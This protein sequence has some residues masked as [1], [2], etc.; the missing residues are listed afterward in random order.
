MLVARVHARKTRTLS[1]VTAIARANAA[2]RSV[3]ANFDQNLEALLRMSLRDPRVCDP[4][5]GSNHRVG[6][7]STARAVLLL[8]SLD[9]C[10]DVATPRSPSKSA[11][12]SVLSALTAGS[13]ALRLFLIVSQSSHLF[14]PVRTKVFISPTKLCRSVRR[15][16]H[17]EISISVFMKLASD[18]PGRREALASQAG[19]LSRA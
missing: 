12:V 9:S 13:S 8:G 16:S 5:S 2:T 19:R 7:H 3:R 10:H 14:A 15:S 1:S 17:P 11:A 18:T 4:D 6:F